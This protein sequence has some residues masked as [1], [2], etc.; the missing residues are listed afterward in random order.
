MAKRNWWAWG[1][2]TAA[3]MAGSKGMMA[4]ERLL[5]PP[6]GLPA[7]PATPAPLAPPP[8]LRPDGAP[9]V[10][11]A[12]ATP[13][14][15]APLPAATALPERTPIADAAPIDAAGGLRG[16]V[17][18]A[19]NKHTEQLVTLEWV[20]PVQIK[21]GQPFVYE[22]VVRNL[23]SVTASNVTVRDQVRDGM[24]ARAIDPPAVQ[25]AD[26]FSWNLGSMEPRQEKRIKI[27]M[28]AERKG[29]ISCQATVTATSPA[30]ARFRVCE[31]ALTLRQSAPESVMIG[32]PVT[33][34][35]AISNPG[36]GP[37]DN[38]IIRSVLSEGLKHAKGSEF[39]YEIGTL[40]AG[41]TRSLQLVC[42]TV[43][44]GKQTVQTMATA[45][46]GLE[47]EAKSMTQVTQ[48]K[49]ELA[50]NG[51]K[52]RYLD[53]AATYTVVVANP[54]DAPANNVKVSAMLPVGFKY[55]SS[56]NGGQ[57]DYTT[58][59]VGWFV[60]TLAPGDK[61]EMSYNA[62]AMQ[63]GQQQHEATVQAHGGLRELAEVVTSVE[64]ISALLLEVVDIDD[65]V[66]V[67]AD[68]AYEIRVTN[69]GSREATN[70]EINALVPREMQVRGAQGPSPFRTQ[71][72]E[73][74]FSPLPKLAPRADAIFRIFVK[75]T[76]VGD[77]RFRARLTSDSLTEPVLEEES[78]KI[79]SD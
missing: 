55:N 15:P 57:H 17:V 26:G 37:A 23:G 71:G 2:L 62:T 7:G 9:P 42:T 59:T 74:Y 77:V 29:V 19:L 1:I 79:Y 39:S 64:G 5:P 6:M 60:G 53:R 24:K 67:G 16:N 45:D 30:L 51:P 76:A 25:D 50:L 68:T 54:G 47:S 32:E 13:T 49:I 63:P 35:V 3:V 65:P 27:E 28:I 11:P 14:N 46:G 18:D 75:G 72:Q 73:V 10:A 56:S 38:V 70:V 52:L 36:D 40:A 44:G 8:A 41:E 31:P 33:V 58:R 78:T 48:A 4:D 66:E 61:R 69:Q 21:V 20:G 34:T 22:I 12:S 43:K